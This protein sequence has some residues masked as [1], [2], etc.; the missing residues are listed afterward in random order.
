[1][2]KQIEVFNDGSEYT[3]SNADLERAKEFIKTEPVYSEDLVPSKTPIIEEPAN[4]LEFPISRFVHFK[5]KKFES[6]NWVSYRAG[7]REIKIGTI[8]GA[9]TGKDADVLLDI[10]PRYMF[11]EKNY[12]FIILSES[13]ALKDLGIPDNWKNRQRMR[14]RI[15]KIIDTQM[16]YYNWEIILKKDNKREKFFIPSIIKTKLFPDAVRDDNGVWKILCHP[17][18]YKNL[19]RKMLRK[20]ILL[21]IGDSHIK[22]IYRYLDKKMGGGQVG[23]HKEGLSKLIMKCGITD[24]KFRRTKR[25]LIKYLEKLKKA[26]KVADWE[27]TYTIKGDFFTCKKEK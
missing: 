23:T 15:D 25:R 12:A 10:F 26:Y 19:Y 17:I 8:Q 13:Q 7:D 11:E 27:F 9:L 4:L 20:D 16:D 1:M 24:T 5:T 14:E 18:V 22:H 6:K 21:A 3:L 2:E